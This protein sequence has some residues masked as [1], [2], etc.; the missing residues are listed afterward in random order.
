[1]SIIPEG[2]QTVV[3]LSPSGFPIV[4]DIEFQVTNPGIELGRQRWIVIVPV[5]T[6]SWNVSTP[7][8]GIVGP[9]HLGGRT[10]RRRDGLGETQFACCTLCHSMPTVQFCRS[11]RL[12]WRRENCI[13]S[14]CSVCGFREGRGNRQQFLDC[15]RGSGTYMPGRDIMLPGKSVVSSFLACYFTSGSTAT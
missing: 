13:Q 10:E 3:A 15:V 6:Q 12:W 2:I 4:V 14:G 8:V 5:F 7:V 11:C 9:D 1:M